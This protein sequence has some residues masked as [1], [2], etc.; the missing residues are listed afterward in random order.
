MTTIL[1]IGKL[2]DIKESKVKELTYDNIYKK[3]GFQNANNFSCQTSWENEPGQSIQ[4]WAKVNGKSGTE[5]K[6]E[7]PPPVDTSLFF[8][9]C[10]LL[11]VDNNTNKIVDLYENEWKKIYEKLFGGFEQIADTEK[12][13]EEEE[14]EL[15]NVPSEM[16]TKNG[17][18]KDGFVVDSNSDNTSET[19]FEES[20]SDDTDTGS[21][22]STYIGESDSEDDDDDLDSDDDE[23]KTEKY[24]YS[25]ED[26]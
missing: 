12:E 25:D 22:A 4:L 7:F 3:C 10:A 24:E 1:I 23:L 11:C 6:Y 8:G 15:D 14:D 16:K 18:L 2:G 19:E 21:E 17:Y 26:D 20:H 13:D 5:N 9:N